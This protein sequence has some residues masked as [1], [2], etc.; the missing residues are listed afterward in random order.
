MTTPNS[1]QHDAWLNGQIGVA[2]GTM[3]GIARMLRSSATWQRVMSATAG[4]HAEDA[5]LGVYLRM[6]PPEINAPWASL[7]SGQEFGY[8]LTAG[9]ERNNL[10]PAGSTVV[11]I[12]TP[13]PEDYHA[14]SIAADHHGVSL[15]S[16]LVEEIVGLSGYDDLPTLVSVTQIA[17]GQTPEEERPARGVVFQSVFEFRWGDE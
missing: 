1:P 9:G 11:I 14:D 13:I 6:V 10:R 8:R 15:H 16:L 7:Q 17:S 3:A 2:A 4:L 12:E 5:E